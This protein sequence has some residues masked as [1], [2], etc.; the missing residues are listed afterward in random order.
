MKS[1]TTRIVADA[2]ELSLPE[3]IIEAVRDLDAPGRGNAFGQG[4]RGDVLVF[5][6]G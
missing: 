6:A 1:R 4:S 3:G 5:P 2:A